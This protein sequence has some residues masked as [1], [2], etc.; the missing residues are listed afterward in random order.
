[1]K[2]QIAFPFLKGFWLFLKVCVLHPAD[3]GTGTPCNLGWP[4][5]SGTTGKGWNPSL[6]SSG[7]TDPDSV[8]SVSPQCVRGP[9]SHCKP[10]R[11]KFAQRSVSLPQASS[12]Y[13]PVCKHQGLKEGGSFSLPSQI[14]CV[15]CGHLSV[16]SLPGATTLRLLQPPSALNS[17]HWPS[18][19]VHEV[20]GVEL[21]TWTL[22]GPVWLADWISPTTAGEAT[23][24]WPSAWPQQKRPLQPHR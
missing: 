13:F 16:V 15:Q 6:R 2:P 1:M 8:M 21:M 5:S 22:R 10:C 9:Q 18:E 11:L 23:G 12:E 4:V 19:R 20:P 17:C 24:S 14:L 3:P 7:L